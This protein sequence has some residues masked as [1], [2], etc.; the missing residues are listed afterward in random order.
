MLS[1][2]IPS[3]KE[4]FNLALLTYPIQVFF[5]SNENISIETGSL[6]IPIRSDINIQIDWNMFGKTLKKYLQYSTL[7][8][9]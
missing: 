1:I 8:G 2:P 9:K 6:I 7:T 3:T 5:N 4:K